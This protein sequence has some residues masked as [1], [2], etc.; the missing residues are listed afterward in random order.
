MEVAHQSLA[1]AVGGP[2][3][4]GRAHRAKPAS[5]NL[6]VGHPSGCEWLPPQH[7]LRSAP[8]MAAATAAILVMATGQRRPSGRQTGLQS[9]RAGDRKPRDR[10]GKLVRGCVWFDVTLS[11]PLGLQLEDSPQ[12]GSRV[13]AIG[14][15]GSAAD[16][17]KLH[18][19]GNEDDFRRYFFIQEGDKLLMVNSTPVKSTE[20][21]VECITGA[22]D[23]QA[24][25]LKFERLALGNVKVIFPEDG[26]EITAPGSA[27]VAAAA[28]AA[29]H[30]VEYKC[31]DGTCGRCWR[32]DHDANEVYRLCIDDFTVGK[33]PSKTIFK[34]DSPFWDEKQYQER[35]KNNPYF[36]NREPLVLKSCPEDYELWRKENPLGAL[37]SDV[38]ASRFRGA[39]EGLTDLSEVPDSKPT[40]W[41]GGKSWSGFE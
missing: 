28:A 5:P 33:I 14:D 41:G 36:D 38:I 7:D 2:L 34:E 22:A 10:E 26:T 35:A 29:G 11:L 40:K 21:A 37:A 3:V 9:R 32:K 13:T 16:H 8:V 19:F 27:Q 20:H 6:R 15:S 23:K 39:L 25:K 31:T 18:T 17:N 24:L 30:E 1:F 4:A 12:G